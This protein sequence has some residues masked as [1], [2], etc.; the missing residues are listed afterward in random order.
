MLINIGHENYVERDRV[1]AVIPPGSAPAKRLRESAAKSGA[2]IDATAGRQTRSL[3]VT[4][5]YLVASSLQPE[6]MRARL[7]SN[8]NFPEKHRTGKEHP[9]NAFV[10]S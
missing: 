2:L 1:V 9:G 10:P 4:P 5:D 7:D 6:T 3:V 8:P